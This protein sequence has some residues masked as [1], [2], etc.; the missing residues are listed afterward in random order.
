MRGACGQVPPPPLHP[1]MKSLKTRKCTLMTYEYGAFYYWRGMKTGH[2]FLSPPPKKKKKKKKNFQ[3]WQYFPNFR[4]TLARTLPDTTT[5]CPYLVRITS[6]GYIYIFTIPLYVEW[7]LLEGVLIQL[8]IPTC[9]STYTCTLLSAD[10]MIIIINLQ[11]KFTRNV[12]NDC[13]DV[14]FDDV[15]RPVLD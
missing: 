1:K 9:A 6:F 4:P 10:I 3:P 13:L 5:L 7:P 12:L 11:H 15:P 14:K 8:P 2:V